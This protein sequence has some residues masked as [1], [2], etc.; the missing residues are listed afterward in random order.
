MKKAISVLIMIFF[1]CCVL[2]SWRAYLNAAPDFM[3]MPTFDPSE[4]ELSNE[5]Q[6]FQLKA[7]DRHWY[8]SSFA[9]YNETG[10]MEL[11]IQ[12]A[13]DEAGQAY[14]M[15]G[16][17]RID[18]SHFP[19][20]GFSDLNN[21]YAEW[22]AVPEVDEYGRTIYVVGNNPNIEQLSFMAELRYRTDIPGMTGDDAICSYV[23]TMNLYYAP[24][25]DS[26]IIDANGHQVSEY[27][28]YTITNYDLYGNETMVMLEGPCYMKTDVDGY[29]QMIIYPTGNALCVIRVDDYGRPQWSATYN[30]D[31]SSLLGYNIWTYEAIKE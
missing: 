9:H 13:L 29:L 2:F 8:L 18:V 4:Y 30:K 24:G 20:E 1:S 22:G 7:H 21:I 5:L 11:Q 17:K 31:D 28:G 15:N 23:N 10:E 12:Y 19:R 25:Q 27:H 16:E 6:T 3:D 14:Y 26:Y